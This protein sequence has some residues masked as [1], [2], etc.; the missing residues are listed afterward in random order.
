MKW[1]FVSIWLHLIR[2]VLSPCL[3]IGWTPHSMWRI[4]MQRKTTCLL[5]IRKSLGCAKNIKI[6]NNNYVYHQSQVWRPIG[7]EVKWAKCSLIIWTG[8]CVQILAWSV[9][10]QSVYEWAF[11]LLVIWCLRFLRIKACIQQRKTRRRVNAC[12]KCNAA[13]SNVGFTT[14]FIV[15]EDI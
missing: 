11:S 10:T 15:T 14:L 9:I 2:I 13:V 4:H 5:S 7:C 1:M 12:N 3:Y 6:N 8:C